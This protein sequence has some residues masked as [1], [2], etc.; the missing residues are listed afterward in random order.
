MSNY[1][2][3]SQSHSYKP[4]NLQTHNP[5][6]T[7]VSKLQNL[8]RVQT[9]SQASTSKT[10]TKSQKKFQNKCRLHITAAS[11]KINT[12]CSQKESSHRLSLNRRQLP[13]TSFDH[14]RPNSYYSLIRRRLSLIRKQPDYY[15]LEAAANCS[16]KK[17]AAPPDLN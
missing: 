13:T 15:N 4:T 11:S 8:P 3:P 1:L 9:E 12:H 2:K 5:Q 17:A 14:R 10:E 16:Q 6:I 7:S